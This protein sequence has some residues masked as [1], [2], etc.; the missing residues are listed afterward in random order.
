MKLSSATLADLPEGVIRPEYPRN[1]TSIGMVHI[2]VGGFHR[3]HQAIY[4]EQ[5]L[6]LGHATQWR[7]CGAGVRSADKAMKDALAA[8]DYLYTLCELDESDNTAIQIV[9]AIADFLLVDED[10][11]ALLDR[12]SSPDTRIVSLT[13]TEGGYFTDD[14]SG[15][16]KTSDPAIVRDLENPTSPMTMVG[17]IAEG[18]FRRRAAGIKPFTVMSCDNLPHNG[19]V[20]RKAVLSYAAL[21]DKALHDWINAEVSFPNGMVDRIT[22]M[23]SDQHRQQLEARTGIIDAWPVVAEPFLQ[24]VL[25]DKFCNGRPEWERVGVQFTDDVTPYEEMKIGLLNGGHLAMTFLGTLL[26][27][28]YAH[29]VMADELLSNYVRDYMDKDVTPLL[30]DVPGIDLSEYK[31]TLIQRFSNRAICDQLTRICSDAAA[32]FPKFVLPTLRGQIKRGMPLDRTALIIAA[33]THYLQGVD[34]AGREYPILDPQL[35]LLRQT[36]AE[37]ALI[38]PGMLAIEDV[39]GQDL[40]ESDA[41]VSAFSEQLLRL[42]TLGVHQTLKLLSSSISR[43]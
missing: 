43:K 7:I 14:S 5:L 40:G 28:E 21:R 11:Q 19:D 30:S 1:E 25:E 23:T 12:L 36:V 27:Y 29:E 33:W 13:V 17:L 31:D 41:F 15:E 3:A 32:K 42:Q 8:Q 39:F 24:W 18:L 20:A 38:V 2:G 26:G 22:P 35:S 4:T 6:N 34:E 16:F 37:P 10:H 9:G